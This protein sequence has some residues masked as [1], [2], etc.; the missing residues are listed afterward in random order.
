ML[1]F[2]ENM[3]SIFFNFIFSIL[4]I[5]IQFVQFKKKYTHNFYMIHNVVNEN[6]IVNRGQGILTADVFITQLSSNARISL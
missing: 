6:I 2:Y 1:Y 3:K 4:F 5:I